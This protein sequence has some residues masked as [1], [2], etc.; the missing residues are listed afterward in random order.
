MV[1]AY[2]LPPNAE[3]VKIMR[4]LVKETMSREQVE[5]L[6]AGHRRRL[7]HAR[8]EG[9]GPPVRASQGQAGD[10]LLNRCRRPARVDP[11]AP[12]SLVGRMSSTPRSPSMAQDRHR[13]TP[14]SRV[15]EREPAASPTSSARRPSAER[16]C[17]RRP[18]S[19]WCGRTRRP[20]TPTWRC[21]TTRSGRRR[22][23]CTSP[24]GTWAADGLLAIFF[25]VVGWSSS[26]SSSPATCATRAAPRCRS[27][28]RSAAW[29]CRRCV[30]VLVNL[31]TGGGRAAGL[32]DPDRH[33]HR[34]RAWRS[35]R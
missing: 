3:D 26:A 9:R 17:S 20:V 23:T 25:F 13:T 31:G 33:R 30:Y 19:R 34:V 1:P 35:W 11:G 14:R 10:R 4:A 2:T 22:C 16:C 5:R 6:P 24:S 18:W 32:G 29:P 27:S 21:A 28:P 7:R 15:V 12:G 8:P